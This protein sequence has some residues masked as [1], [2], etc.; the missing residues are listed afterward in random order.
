MHSHSCSPCIC[1]FAA[2][3]CNGDPNAA[4]HQHRLVLLRLFNAVGALQFNLLNSHVEPCLLSVSMPRTY[5]CFYVYVYV[6]TSDIALPV[7]LAGLYLAENL[8][9]GTLPESWSDLSSVSH[10]CDMVWLLIEV[11][12]FLQH[13]QALERSGCS[14]CCNLLSSEGVV[15]YCW[16]ACRCNNVQI[17]PIVQ[18]A[19]IHCC[20]VCSIFPNMML[21]LDCNAFSHLDTSCWRSCKS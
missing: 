8:L 2:E 11:D 12:V 19:C 16:A 5:V 15:G 4:P 10:C 6:C 17:D 21:Q 14:W 1:A 9:E 3:T 20:K 18:L 13:C 7:Q